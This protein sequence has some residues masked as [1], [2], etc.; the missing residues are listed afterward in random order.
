MKIYVIGTVRSFWPKLIQNLFEV[1]KGMGHEVWLDLH[2]P[3]NDKDYSV[4]NILTIGI[5]LDVKVKN[6]PK[7][8]IMW[9]SEPINSYIGM[10]PGHI[11]KLKRAHAIFHYNKLEID[12][13]KRY[14]KNVFY[15]PYG[16]G[17]TLERIT[18]QPEPVKQDIDV[19][20][21][22]SIYRNEKNTLGKHRVDTLN[23]LLSKGI[24]LCATGIN[25]PYIYRDDKY[26]LLTRAKI[27]L[28]TNYYEGNVDTCRATDMIINKKFI[29]VDSW[30][31][32]DE[33]GGIYNNTIPIVKTE[34]LV[35]KI[36]YYLKNPDER[37]KVINNSYEYIKEHFTYERFLSDIP[38]LSD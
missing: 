16:Y 29:I 17:K 10:M 5:F 9:N 2:L 38:L 22:G 19:L 30:G 31:G 4:L 18:N 3:N 15:L 14:N 32:A 6:L 27:V 25:I 12:L 37:E 8:Y 11:E 21:I 20:F 33:L 36:N 35:S 28:L 26:K 7:K 24:N 23:M 34:D 13:M 1:L